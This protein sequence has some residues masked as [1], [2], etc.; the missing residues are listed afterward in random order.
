MFIA[1]LW[2]QFGPEIYLGFEQTRRELGGAFFAQTFTD[3]TSGSG[4][5]EGLGQVGDA[6]DLN[7]SPPTNNFG[8]FLSFDTAIDG[9]DIALAYLDA[10]GCDVLR[11]GGCLTFLL[12]DG[13]TGE[14]PTRWYT[15]DAYFDLTQHGYLYAGMTNEERQASLDDAAAGIWRA[16]SG[17]VVSLFGMLEQIVQLLLTI[18]FGIGFAS[19]FIAILF[20]FFKRTETITQSVFDILIG[21]FIQSIITSLLLAL[22]MAFVSVAGATGNG[23]LLL[24]VGFIGI[25]LVAVLL[26]GAVSAILQALNGLMKSFGSVTG[27]NIDGAGS[28]AKVAGAVAAGATGGATLLAGGTAAQALG[29]VGGPKIGQQAYYA[30]RALGTDSVLGRA[31]TQ[32]AEGS[33][34]AYA[35][36]LGGYALGAQ[37]GAQRDAEN[38]RAMTLGTPIT[39]DRPDGSYDTVVGDTK[40]R[41][42]AADGQDLRYDPVVDRNYAFN[43]QDNGDGLRT[44][45]DGSTLRTDG[46]D[47]PDDIARSRAEKRLRSVYRVDDDPDD[48]VPALPSGGGGLRQSDID[49]VDASDDNE[50]AAIVASI[51]GLSAS[52]GA[53]NTSGGDS[54][55]DNGNDNNVSVV[56]AS[57]DSSS[58]DSTSSG[59][60]TSSNGGGSADVNA[61]SE[62]FVAGI[63]RDY[64]GSTGRPDL[65][66]R[67][68]PENNQPAPAPAT[69]SVP[70]QPPTEPVVTPQP[71]VSSPS[72]NVVSGSPDDL[73]TSIPSIGASTQKRLEGIGITT[74]GQL[75][76]ADPQQLATV[77][78]I[79][80]ARADQLVNAAQQYVTPPS[81][82]SS[83]VDSGTSTTSGGVSE[84]SPPSTQAFA[85]ISINPPVSSPPVAPT[86]PPAAPT[87]PPVAPTLPPVA[88]TPPPTAPTAP[89]TV[90]VQGT[91]SPVVTTPTPN[92]AQ[93]ASAIDASNNDDGVRLATSIGSAINTAM[94]SG[95]VPSPSQ[96]QQIA[97]QSGLPPGRE[98]TQ[99]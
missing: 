32:V 6:G 96:A 24:G 37:T 31:A 69:V 52:L 56:V 71:S 67:Y 7:I 27:G 60:D 17:I 2:F 92:A 85:P 61:A 95:R 77:D 75:A 57:A 64:P 93:F 30:S 18:A 50:N 47:V 91:Q 8:A 51:S 28:V 20:A 39:V 1:I 43:R 34:A 48:A 12:P 98:S 13:S 78:R 79:T 72:T 58:D 14:L 97:T 80:P 15:A 42:L 25:I 49:R 94:S 29:A 45:E 19:F 10:D 73:V 38:V 55:S 4:S 59:E 90:V 89:P 74:A 5:I 70:V 22:V 66:D 3:L 11:T 33:A 84:L 54:S 81:N 76:D 63:E 16:L 53:L 36:P 46:D 26:F 86:P 65:V 9:L 41:N 68:F 35:G 99:F 83:S 23:I 87:S 40:L 62:S 82:E 88:P 44:Y 21:L